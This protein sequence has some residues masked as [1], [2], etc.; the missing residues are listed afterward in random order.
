MWRPKELRGIKKG[1]EIAHQCYGPNCAKASRTNSKYCSDECGLQLA[2][3]RLKNIL[4]G[5]VSD[6]YMLQPFAEKIDDKKI[7]EL[8]VKKAETESDLELA[9]KYA[10]LFDLYISVSSS[11][12]Y[13]HSIF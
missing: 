2:D 12:S 5:R 8:T 9:N 7:R 1:D 10:E 6:F 3:L 13:I 11:N 4:R